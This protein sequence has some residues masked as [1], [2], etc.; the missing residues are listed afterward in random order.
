MSEVRLGFGWYSGLA[1]FIAVTF[2]ATGGN[3]QNP[4][5]LNEVEAKPRPNALD[6][7]D[8]WVLKMRFNPPRLITVDIPG[9]G[10]KLCWYLLYHVTN[11]D[12]KEPHTFIPDFQL[13]TLDNPAVFHD[14]VLPT[15]QKAIQKIEDPTGLLD[16]KNSVS[17]S[18]KP[19]P[20]T[21]PESTSRY[22]TGVAIWD[23]VSPDTNQFSIFASGLSN[24]WSVDDQEVIRRKTLQLNF[25][26]LGDKTNQDARDIRFIPPEEWIYRATTSKTPDAKPKEKESGALNS[27]GGSKSTTPKR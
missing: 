11:A 23:D 16:I 19:L 22:V 7:G 15:V 4:I 3:A 27:P 6:K 18:D 14:Q 9:R 2:W 12:S 25:R 8:I 13:V 21:K 20:P 5:N 17:I 10:R 1:I 24:G 26:R